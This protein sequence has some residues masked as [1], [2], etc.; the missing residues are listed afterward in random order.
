MNTLQKAKSVAALSLA[1]LTAACG[2]SKTEPATE[3]SR[4]NLSGEELLIQ[5]ADEYQGISDQTEGL[6]TTSGQSVFYSVEPFHITKGRNKHGI[7]LIA[8]VPGQV[9]YHC[10]LRARE[11]KTVPGGVEFVADSVPYNAKYPAAQNPNTPGPDSTWTGWIKTSARV[12][13]PALAAQ[14]DRA[15]QDCEQIRGSIMIALATRMDPTIDLQVPASYIA[16]P[17]TTHQDTLA[18]SAPVEKDSTR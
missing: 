15:A 5:A 8:E 14:D 6:P 3:S 13:N 7:H 11:S 16:T 1:A 9:Q 10:W 2:G 17:R 18:A 12:V 4:D